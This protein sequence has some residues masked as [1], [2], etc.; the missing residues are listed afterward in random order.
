MEWP[1][2]VLPNKNAYAP[3]SLFT[4]VFTSQLVCKTSTATHLL[5]IFLETELMHALRNASAASHKTCENTCS[6][7]T[8]WVCESVQIIP[9]CSTV[10]VTKNIHSHNKHDHVVEQSHDSHTQ[11]R[12]AVVGFEERC[13][14][15]VK[16][17]KIQPYLSPF[18]FL[19]FVV[20]LWHAR[21]GPVAT[22]MDPLTREK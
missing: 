19:Y 11:L 5:M 1:P 2:S 6:T 3:A 12:S 22:G 4:T 7:C 21:G 17:H 8:S 20:S 14:F 10:T 13:H 15:T 18:I 16:P 9:M